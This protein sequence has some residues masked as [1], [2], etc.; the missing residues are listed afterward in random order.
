MNGNFKLRAVSLSQQI[1]HDT[2][3]RFFAVLTWRYGRLY[4]DALDK[5]EKIQRLRH[6]TGLTRQELLAVCENIIETVTPEDFVQDPSLPEAEVEEEEI[7][8]LTPAEMLR[9]MLKCEWLEEPKRSDYQRVYYLD[10]RAELLLESLRRIAYPEQITFTDKLH[11]VFKHLMDED[12][13]TDHPLSD[14]ESCADNLRYG[15]Q[16]LRSM[17]QGMARLTQRQLRSDSLK[18]NLQVLYDDFSANIGQKCYK[19]LIGLDIPIRV[20]MVKQSLLN[21]ENNPMI[22]SKMEAE[23]AKRRTE[24]GDFEITKLVAEKLRELTAMI[25]SVEPQSEAVD[26]RAADFA[27]RSFARF[28]YLQEVSSGRRSEVRQLFEKV[29]ERFAECRMAN[30]PEQLDLPKLK[31]P[32]VGLLSGIDS[33]SIPNP[34]IQRNYDR[35]PLVDDFD[36][37]DHDFAVDEMQE[38]INSS[39]TSLRAN[40]FF[41]SLGVPKDG[42]NAADFPTDE[43]WLLE[44][45]GL[46][47][48]AD[49]SDSDFDLTTPREEYLEPVRH[50]KDDYLI[51]DF[52]I[53]AKPKS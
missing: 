51:D 53:K 34:K 29:N 42:L 38:N 21:I 46:L 48:H 52:T 28:R 23:L 26:R 37:D 4:I 24:L 47:L 13:F 6:G 30:L 27:R 11:L 32:S 19:S 20:P 36:I 1:F 39:L 35:S 17:Q 50:L 49:T 10:S 45:T 15:L 9:Q 7:N 43:A 33:L 31:I 14:L 44:L 12:S 40:R 3:T 41:H 16:E 22:V 18:E 2:P 8:K 5:M 25:D